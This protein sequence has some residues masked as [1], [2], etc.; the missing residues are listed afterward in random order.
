MLRGEMVMSA[1][2]SGP[3]D[4]VDQPPAA[5]RFTGRSAIVTGAGQ[6]LGKAIAMQLAREGARVAVV[7]RDRSSAEAVA[8]VITS[9]GGIAIALAADVS[10]ADQIGSAIEQAAAAHGGLHLAVN[11]AGVSSQPA[12]TADQSLAAWDRAIAINLGGIFYSLKF[13]L[14]EMLKSGGGAIVNVSSIFGSRGLPHHAPYA[15]AKHGVIGLSR[16]AAAEYASQGIRINVL[17]PGPFDTPMGA[18]S[19]VTQEMIAAM[20]PLGRI[21][22]P[23]EASAV[24][25]FLLSDEA[26]FVVGGEFGCDGGMLR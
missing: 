18:S 7:D 5:H 17:S 9:D 19:G 11:N 21:G 15:A 1:Q 3:L 13:E 10:Q 25:C 22:R 2:G 8:T 14:P 4:T 24:A 6:G 12:L 16:S 23:D 26:S 20:V